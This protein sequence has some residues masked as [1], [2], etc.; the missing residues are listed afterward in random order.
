[1]NRRSTFSAPDE[2]SLSSED[3]DIET[4]SDFY[5]SLPSTDSEPSQALTSFFQSLLEYNRRTM[6]DTTM[7]DATPKISMKE[8]KFNVPKA[9]SGKRGDLKKFLQTCRM[10]LQTNSEMYNT[11][12]RKVVFTLSF[13]TEG[14]VANWKDQWL[15]EL[16]EEATK[17]KSSKLDFGNYEDFLDLLKKDFAEYDAPGDALNEMKTLR[18]DPKTSID[19]H[20]S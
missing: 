10:Y 12:E 5:H 13:M 11:D 14:D 3:F 16:E 15:D 17:K 2:S 1:M 8:A 19:D 18:Y 7:I 20:I 9:F 4:T 6:A